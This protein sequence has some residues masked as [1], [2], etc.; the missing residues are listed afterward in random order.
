MENIELKI[1]IG[2]HRNV[3]SI[4]R[5]TSRLCQEYGLTFSQ[6]M[7]M[8][9]LYSKGDMTVGQVRDKILSTAGTIPLIVNNLVKLGYIE[10]LK[11]ENDKRVSILHL[12]QAGFK[13]I[14]EVAGKNV[15]LIVES[16]ENLDDRDKEDLL[17]LLKKMGGRLDGKKDKE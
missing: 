13:L 3:N 1:L 7:V 16:M 10:R 5:K 12:T 11:D 8:E 2:L 9:A 15:D 14:E 6:F 17:Y 4:D